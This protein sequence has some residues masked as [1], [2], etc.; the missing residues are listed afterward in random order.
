MRGVA[1]VEERRIQTHRDLKVWQLGM[2]IAELIYQTTKAFP[3][4][5]RFGLISQLRRAAV[6]IPANIAEGNARDSTKEYLRHLSIAVGSL[7]E[8]ETLVDLARRL[9]FGQSSS[10]HTLSELLS[11]ERRMLRG[12]QRSIRAKLDANRSDL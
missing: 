9:S 5:E 4:D 2:E 11:E 10:I 8:I 3:D 1:T 7:A 6:S 12:L